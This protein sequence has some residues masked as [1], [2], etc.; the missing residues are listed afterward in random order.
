LEFQF[1]LAESNGYVDDG[2]A[3]LFRKLTARIDTIIPDD[4]EPPSLLHGDLWGGN[5]LCLGGTVPALI[6]PAVYFG[7]READIAMTLLFG[8]FDDA[9]YSAY[10]EEYPLGSGWKE[11]LPVYSLYHL[12]N[13]LNLFGAGYH[14]QV[15]ETMRRLTK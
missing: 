14:G 2:M 5:L 6:D 15:M 12:F 10:N 7:H 3:S 11:R 13:H 4:G 9:F 1:R 8:G